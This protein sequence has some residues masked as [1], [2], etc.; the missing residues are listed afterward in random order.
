M[1]FPILLAA[2]AVGTAISIY[3]QIKGAE[4]E[5]DAARR[6]AAARELE[7]Q[8]I[9]KRTK[10]NQDIVQEEGDILMGN[11]QTYF[12]MGGSL[13]GSPLMT[14]ERTAHSIAREKQNMQIE[15]DFKAA[16]L[17]SGAAISTEL[18]GQ[19]QQAG[20]IGAA[21][22]VLTSAYQIGSAMQ[23]TPKNKVSVE[24]NSSGGGGGSG[25]S[26]MSGSI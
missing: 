16:Q 7:A 4:A 2:Y 22:T 18:A 21:G 11:Q 19:R 8:E 1:A 17:R 13:I 10:V 25:R 3:G 5:A 12:S 14:L 26:L 15:A 20:Y 23:K 6:E 9:L 24:T